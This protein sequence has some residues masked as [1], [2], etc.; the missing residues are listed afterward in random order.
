[1]TASELRVGNYI[2]Y[3]N[4]LYVVTGMK[5]EA[6]LRRMRIYFSTINGELKNAKLIEWIKPIELT[7]EILLAVGF[8][9]KEWNNG[10]T[11]GKH[12]TLPIGDTWELIY[13]MLKGKFNCFTI[14]ADGGY[15][16]C[17]IYDISKKCKY[18]HQ[19]QNLYFPFMQ[20][21]LNTSKLFQK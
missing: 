5:E 11:N 10:L 3:L 13:D 6:A 4:D 17:G 19:L 9:M 20:E 18:L 12:F 16:E 2:L 8:E 1:M 7:E 15:D 21:E 14:Q